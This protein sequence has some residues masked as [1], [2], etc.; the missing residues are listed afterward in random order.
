MA[1]TGSIASRLD[2]LWL[3]GRPTFRPTCFRPIHPILTYPNRIGRKTLD[4]NLLDENRLDKD[5]AHGLHTEICIA[6][7]KSPKFIQSNKIIWYAIED[8]KILGN[9]D[10]VQYAMLLLVKFSV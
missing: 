3:H 1:A 4:E 5:W 7:S 6:Y 10:I 2:C 8:I 9:V